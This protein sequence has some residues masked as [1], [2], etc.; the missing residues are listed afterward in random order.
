M[1][2]LY[3]TLIVEDEDIVREGLIETIE[4][5]KIGLDRKSVV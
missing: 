5:E 1:K 3:T 2:K 4:W